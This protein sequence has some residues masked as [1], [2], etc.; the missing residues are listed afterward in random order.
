MAKSKLCSDHSR[1]WET[2]DDD[3]VE[4]LASEAFAS[5]HS[6]FKHI[7]A[8]QEIENLRSYAASTLERA[9]WNWL[10]R[11]YPERHS[12]KREIV[13][14]LEFDPRLDLWAL[15]ANLHVA[16]FAQDSGKSATRN[17]NTLLMASRPEEAIR[18]CFPLNNPEELLLP[19][20]LIIVFGWIPGPHERNS[21]VS[22]S[23]VALNRLARTELSQEDLLEQSVPESSTDELTVR[24]ILSAVW[25]ELAE[26]EEE[27]R[28]VFLLFE[29][30]GREQDPLV[31]L[32]ILEGIANLE[33]IATFVGITL[34][35][36]CAF[37]KAERVT[38]EQVSQLYEL[39][40]KQ[41]EGIRRGVVERLARRLE[42]RGLYAAF[43]NPEREVANC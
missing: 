11:K 7:A 2:E 27:K 37:S 4:Q 13:H 6:R 43:S 16:G 35:Q 12:L 18:L 22:F 32:L 24:S 30:P 26:L 9:Y 17:A 14:V 5:V 36:I 34:E 39:P 41:A 31:N 3:V 33:E 29:P 40:T 1:R 42:R 21:L 20:Y 10:K 15:P 8:G 23:S 19:D 38:L 25:Q 28:G